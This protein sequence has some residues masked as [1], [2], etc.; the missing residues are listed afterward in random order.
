MSRPARS[1]LALLVACVALAAPAAAGA[2]TVVNGDFES[3]NLD[4]WRVQRTTEAGD[5]FA[6]SGEG[7]GVVAPPSGNFGAVANEINKDALILYQDVTL[8]PL[9][10]HQL[11]LFV[12]YHSVAPIAVPDPNTLQLDAAEDNQQMRVDVIKPTASLDSLAPGDILTTVFANR[13]GD[14]ADMAP[15]K[16]SADLTP[17]A[18]QTV[19][20]RVATVAQ[21]QVFN[22]SVD[23]VSIASTPPPPPPPSNAFTRGKLTLNKSKGTGKLA[24][25]VPGPGTLTA[26]DEGRAKKVKRANL[27]VT[28]A[29]TVKVPLNPTA[30]GL[31]VLNAKGKLKARIDVTFTPT[32]GSVATQTYKVTL[33]KTL[34]K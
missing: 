6:Y 32:G 29:G 24:I 28:A 16:F 5:W 8:E 13:N 26:V 30:K 11:S 19:R 3:G 18:G 14:P 33:K 9:F 17:F 1:S 10:A 4:G 31:K 2:A 22:A 15:T 7:L 34:P 25:Y 12:Y 23:D 21:E 20:I 27:T